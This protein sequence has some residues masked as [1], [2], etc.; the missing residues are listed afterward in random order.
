VAAIIAIGFPSSSLAA[1]CCAQDDTRVFQ[2]PQYSYS[3][4]WLRNFANPNY[5]RMVLCNGSCAY[6]STEE[7]PGCNLVPLYPILAPPRGGCPMKNGI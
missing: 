1:D 4:R 5:C 2:R 6:T 3:E 7:E